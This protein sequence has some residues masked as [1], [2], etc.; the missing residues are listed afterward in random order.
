MH[1]LS[2]PQTAHQKRKG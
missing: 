2:G 1:G